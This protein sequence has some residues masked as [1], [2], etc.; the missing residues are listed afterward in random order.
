MPED[1]PADDTTSTGS[2]A[3]GE[4]AN[5]GQATAS[6][7][8]SVAA[9]R[10]AQSV[11]KLVNR[12]EEFFEF[13]KKAFEA[14][15]TSAEDLV[16]HTGSVRDNLKSIIAASKKLSQNI[17]FGQATKE[18][19]KMRSEVEHLLKTTK[20]NTTEHRNLRRVQTDL[21]EGERLLEKHKGESNKSLKSDVELAKQ[22]KTIMHSVED[23]TVKIASAYNTV[24]TGK[25]NQAFMNIHDVM[26]RGGARVHNLRRTAQRAH[27]VKLDREDKTA[28]KKAQWE[29]NKKNLIKKIKE[30][31]DADVFFDWEGNFDMKRAFNHPE[32]KKLMMDTMLSGGSEGKGPSNW[33]DRKIAAHA[34]GG[35]GFTN[36]MAGKLMEE[37]GGS[38]AVGGVLG[39]VL[40]GA[41]SLGAG[42]LTKLAGP[43]GLGIAGTLAVKDTFDAVAKQS[44]EMEKSLGKGGIFTGEHGGLEGM[45]NAK[46]NLRAFGLNRFGVTT[47][48][49]IAVAQAM[50]E[51]GVNISG[52]ANKGTGMRDSGVG[53]IAEIAMK[54]ARELGLSDVEG[55]KQTL[56]MMQNYKLTLD[57]T[58]TFFRTVG[59]DITAAGLSTGKYLELL[60]DVTGQFDSMGKSIETVTTLLRAMGNSGT[61]DADQLKENLTS[62]MGKP[63]TDEQSLFGMFSMSNPAFQRYAKSQQDNAATQIK[64]YKDTIDQAL[65]HMNA[66][67]GASE[68]IWKGLDLTKTKDLDT[69]KS[70]FDEIKEKVGGVSNP[71]TTAVGPNLLN[72]KNAMATAEASKM[73]RLNAATIGGVTD[74]NALSRMN[75]TMNDLNN[76][77]DTA[78]TSTE[79]LVTNS[80]KA[81]NTN[82]LLQKQVSEPL[83]LDPHKMLRISAAVGDI[84]DSIVNEFYNG[85]SASSTAGMGK[86]AID[87][88]YGK[89]L[90]ALGIQY[91]PGEAQKTYQSMDKNV[92]KEKNHV[93]LMQRG[94]L[95]GAVSDSVI[96]KSLDDHHKDSIETV[97]KNNADL[98]MG[99]RTTNGYLEGIE[100]ALINK[101]GWLQKM[102]DIMD[103]HWGLKADVKG[104]AA[105][106]EAATSNQAMSDSELLNQI[107]N[108]IKPDGS[109]TNWDWVDPAA[110]G[111]AKGKSASFIQQRLQELEPLAAAGNLGD[112]KKEYDEFFAARAEMMND[113][114]LQMTG[115][116]AFAGLSAEQRAQG[117]AGIGYDKTTG[118]VISLVGP[119]DV[120]QA[121]DTPAATKVK[122]QTPTVGNV[123]SGNST[124]TTNN[125]LVGGQ[126]VQAATPGA[127][128]AKEQKTQTPAPAGAPVQTPPPHLSGNSGVS[129]GG[130]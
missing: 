98:A 114:K 45:M 44:Q 67:Q 64:K 127:G 104:T 41:E 27:D 51:S 14:T 2:A 48:R 46:D 26:G 1:L 12:L 60:D 42:A 10:M 36:Q 38:G 97:L 53:D 22:L 130:W 107:V 102:F 73:G 122:S 37:T 4:A 25:L 112:R 84:S 11:D 55:T 96:T 57:G 58:Q 124:T 78:G 61:E 69:A 80:T 33:I 28:E 105:A 89:Q 83:G 87:A 95:T 99:T 34:M 66:P 118:K 115:R 90:T 123:N 62:L 43:I 92:L 24:K 82:P 72:A 125:T 121:G 3:P 88:E 119:P 19:Q 8:V 91:K 7:D 31:P 20:E 17:S 56:K 70:R 65:T 6:V 94:A 74:D 16:N 35:F 120:K 32:T 13:Q 126:Q 47:E 76:V 77:L 50:Q 54:Q 15:A 93:A 29:D 40:G 18:V 111:A 86:E 108:S 52:L 103:S 81:L 101:A 39:G 71:F 59:K 109:G 9:L 23:S 100:D 85:L 113:F 116:G 129:V 106:K 21:I 5:I 68:E 79:E 49:N 75:S 63:Q 30:R 110:K 117:N 128:K